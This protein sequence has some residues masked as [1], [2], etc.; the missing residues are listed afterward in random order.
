MPPRPVIADSDDE[1]E[2]DILSSPPRR[3][4]QDAPEIEPLSPFHKP[5]ST[6]ISENHNQTSGTTDQTFFAGVYDEQQ[7]RALHRSHL[8]ENIVRQSQ[9]ASGS[10]GEISLP[11]KGKGKNVNASS[12]T[13]VTSPLVLSRP[14]NQPSLFNDG[15]SSITTPR[16]SMP[17]EWDV[18]SSV[19]SAI[20]PRS[21]ERSRGKNQ[22]S[23]GKRRSQ[24]K[25]IPSSAAAQI[26]IADDAAPWG[27]LQ[28]TA[29]DNEILEAGSAID[30][31]T[32][33]TE[34]RR[35]VSLHNS[36]SQDMP[37]AA[38]FYIA[39]SNLTTMQK[40][41][42]Q[43]VNVSQNSYPSLPDPHTN[44]KSSGMTTIAYPT[45]SRYQSS[46]G[47]PLPWERASA[48]E[49]QTDSLHFVDMTSSPDVIAAGHDGAGR[50]KEATPHADTH[51]VRN[52]IEAPAEDAAMK[53]SSRK[54]RKKRPISMQDEDEL[55]QNDT[56]P[57]KRRRDEM[58]PTSPSQHERDD[59]VDFIN[60]PE[61]VADEKIQ[62]NEFPEEKAHET[63]EL[64]SEIPST[65]P[66]NPLSA[67]ES[68]QLE[69]QLTPQP[70]RRGRKKKQPEN[71]PAIQN[72]E[73]I[74]G[75]AAP[76]AI[77]PIA[78]VPEKIKKKRGRPRKT[79]TAKFERTA[80]M[81]PAARDENV[82]Y[83]ELAS[84]RPEL[85]AVQTK[86]KRQTQRHEGEHRAANI[87][88]PVPTLDRD[89]DRDA[90]PLKEIS[91][92]T[93]FP[94]QNSMLTAGVSAASVAESSARNPPPKPQ[95]IGV[96]TPKPTLTASQSK[97][98]Y[99]VGLSKRSR[100][101]SLLKS[102]RR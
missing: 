1:D 14:G 11:A 2:G 74:E 101:S 98:S 8:I 100:I 93:R 77:T 44:Q 42:Y 88:A 66:A 6:E 18:P 49:M 99:R 21:A 30:P 24:S 55:A 62:L 31:S 86:K 17:G 54:K 70:R 4:V 33:P 97:V 61:A 73:S 82:G 53:I 76:Q 67:L 35:K 36:V 46:P 64:T 65:A 92:N 40:L 72:E 79:D 7:S 94:S 43:R 81:E 63:D 95:E 9:K 12:A 34:K 50:G 78:K 69:I 96:S 68:E 52:E 75:P 90:S 56:W 87:E 85:D 5:P 10:S 22:K 28:D 45:P 20:A 23:Y 80:T 59:D 89:G 102:I 26:F 47:P 84:E 15:T 57:S 32:R 39:Q 51:T 83:D 25:M 91:S 19:E 3:D 13:D 37:A 48:S 60:P 38:N 41:E 58:R 16:K 29:M 27:I 71:D